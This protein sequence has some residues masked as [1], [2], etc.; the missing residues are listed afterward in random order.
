MHEVGIVQSVLEMAEK[1]AKREG[2][3]HVHIIRMRVG[4]L[5]GVVADALEFGF[6]AL[7]VGTIAE[8]GTLEIEQVP[9]RCFCAKCEQEFETS[10]IVYGCPICGELSFDIRAGRELDIISMEV[11]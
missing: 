8:G 9:V 11:S 4:A 10:G 3:A 6:E 2:A 7:S 5:S 1:A